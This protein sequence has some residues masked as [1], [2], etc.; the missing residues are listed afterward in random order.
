[1]LSGANIEACWA[2]GHGRQAQPLPRQRGAVRGGTRFTRYLNTPG[3]HQTEQHWGGGT[4]RECCPKRNKHARHP[5]LTSLA[6]GS[7]LKGK[8]DVRGV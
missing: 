8:C 3:S 2:G 7:C 6:P 4:A 1:M 5:R